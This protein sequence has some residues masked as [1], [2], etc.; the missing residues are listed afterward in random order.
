M[1]HP[2]SKNF[3]SKGRDRFFKEIITKSFSE[4]LNLALKPLQI[5]SCFEASNSPLQYSNDFTRFKFEHE[6]WEE[7]FINGQTRLIAKSRKTPFGHYACLSLCKFLDKDKEYIL[8]IKF[9]INTLS[10]D[11]SFHIKDSGSRFIQ[12]IHKEIIYDNTGCNWN[13]VNIKFK[14]N[15]KVYD[16]FM[17]GAAQISGENNFII[18]DYISITEM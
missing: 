14:P 18:F 10:K 8:D 6:Y 1:I 3:I 4:S 11:I 16:E 9:K 15:A 7:H 12:V 17:I 5:K 2:G 13:I